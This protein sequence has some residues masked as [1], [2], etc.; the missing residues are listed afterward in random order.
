MVA[1]HITNKYMIY[2]K[3]ISN[4]YCILSVKYKEFLQLNKKKTNQIE[5]GQKMST[6]ASPNKVY[7]W[8]TNT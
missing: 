5:N 2:V 8:Q 6:E 7:K 1:I 3:H 4:K